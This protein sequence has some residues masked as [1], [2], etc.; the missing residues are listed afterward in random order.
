M[1]NSF[2]NF[3]IPVTKSAVWVVFFITAVIVIIMAFMFN[4]HWK[5]YGI[6][7]KEA[8]VMKGLYYIGTVILL[9]LT[10]LLAIMF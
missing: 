7:G 8:V 6:S 4:Y 5:Y 3:A 2:S 10:Y 9:G 1:I